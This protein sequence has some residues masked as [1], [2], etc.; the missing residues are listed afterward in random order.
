MKLNFLKTANI[1]MNKKEFL[2]IF[3]LL[4]A[5]LFSFL[6]FRISDQG[7]K[8]EIEISRKLYGTY[9]LLT[10]QEIIIKDNNGYT[11]MNVLIKN[12]K[13]QVLTSNC[14]DKIC[15]ESGS[16]E[17]SGQTIICLPNQVVIKIISDDDTIDGVLQ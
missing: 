7:A 15:I 9:D 11:L 10:E 12:G 16:I 4:I 8:V 3:I 2:I 13:V 14:P 6:I 1:K 17:L 5:A